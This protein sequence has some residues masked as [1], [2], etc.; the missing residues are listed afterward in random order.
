[1][2]RRITL[3]IAG[4]RADLG[5]DAF[6]LLNVALNDVTNPAVV[7]NSWTQEVD[8]PR[9][10]ENDKLFGASFRLDRNA[11]AGGS[12]PDFNA[13]RRVPF[14]I[15]AETGEVLFA[16]Y[17]KLGSVTRDSYRVSLYGG[18]GDF[19]YWLSYDSAGEKRTLASLDYGEDLDF[20]IDR[21][22]VADAWAR[23]GGDLTKPAK[24]DIINFAPCYNGIPGDFKADKALIGLDLLGVVPPVQMDGVDCDATKGGGYALLTLQQA[25]DEW[26]VHDLRS[27][28]QRPVLSVRKL[29]AAIADPQNNGGWTVD[30][31]GL[32][33]VSALDS[34]LTRP[35][36]PSLGTY[37]QTEGDIVLT[38]DGTGSGQ[39]VGRFTVAD[40]PAGTEVTARMQFRP[41]FSIPGATQQTL[42]PKASSGTPRR[43]A[44]QLLFIQ[45][46]AYD[47]ANNPVAYGQVTTLC[48]DDYVDAAATAAFVGYTPEG[49][50]GF[51]GT[52]SDWTYNKVSNG[53]YKR[54]APVS[55]EISGK[56]IHHIDIKQTAY[57]VVYVPGAGAPY[58]YTG[59]GSAA[60]SILFTDQDDRTSHVSC[61]AASGADGS[62]TGTQVSADTLRSGALVTKEMLLSTSATPAEYLVSLCKML[63][64]YIVADGAAK[65]VRIL[66]RSEF[67]QAGALD[68]TK[69]V[70]APSVEI[71]PL[72]FDAKWYEWKH[73]SVGGRF[74]KQY[75]ETEGVQYG[76]QRVDTGYDFDAQEK[77]VL[78]GSAIKS[79]A[80]VQDRGPWWL[81]AYD[82]GLAQM[83]FGPLMTPG[84]EFTL[85]DADGKDHQELATSPTSGAAVAPYNP[86]FPGY[87]VADR[88]E[89]RDADDKALDGADVLLFYQGTQTVDDFNLTDDL[90]AMD[91]LLGGPCWIIDVNNVGLTIPHFSRYRCLVGLDGKPTV[92]SSL[93]FGIPREVDIPGLVYTTGTIYLQA[94]RQYIADRLSVHG[95]VMRCRMVMDGLQVG[96]ELLRRFYWYQGS[97]WALVSVSNYSLTT[98]DPAECEFIQVRDTAAYTNGQS[99]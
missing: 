75:Q 27:Y 87:D 85:W 23:L 74:E 73:P 29:L 53:I 14:S 17:A 45:P 54:F 94:W 51:K 10:P 81:Y 37:K 97:L 18:L 7:R 11:G 32:A 76:I 38:F 72:A 20:T 49:G 28:F 88:A 77:D 21:N 46:V 16:G 34:W 31:S 35:P 61:N 63:G 79:C 47:S 92:V 39:R 58:A 42:F 3:Y 12:G 44:S 30:I 59:T 52:E 71:R 82:T 67:F 43:I 56:N 93:D 84:A 69:R 6:V 24:W 55:L 40:A 1:M 80:S 33:G 96:P 19:L 89:F 9:T 98:F 50:A 41:V 83:W 99:Y 13:S 62:G 70:D 15:Y 68:I 57:A 60:Y 86:T 5:D 22:A 25:M 36:L 66:T 90:P 64:L 8:L 48:G 4:R 26:M 95:K 91:T 78:A 2:R 65:T